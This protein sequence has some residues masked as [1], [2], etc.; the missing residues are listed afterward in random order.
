MTCFAFSVDVFGGHP[1]LPLH[2][3]LLRACVCVCVDCVYRV[4][5][6]LSVFVVS[7]AKTL[8]QE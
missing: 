7:S 3:C 5:A 1:V 2:A 8:F 4:D 6:H